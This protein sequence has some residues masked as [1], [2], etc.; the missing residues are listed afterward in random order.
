MENKPK[1]VVASANA[2]KLKEIKTIFSEFEISG[3]K[4]HG[5]DIEIQ[6]TGTTFYENAL[7]K[8]KTIS[9]I[10]GVPALAD[11]SGLEVDAL[12][13]APGIYSARYA[14]DGDDKHNNL[15]LLE[16]MKG[17]TNRTARFVCSLVYYTPD[18]QIV[19]AFGQTEGEIMHQEQGENGFGYDSLFFSKDL[20]K[21]MGIATPQEKN[22][23]SHRYR[24]LVQLREKL[25]KKL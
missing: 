9:E 25:S 16:N 10:L 20:Q 19:S 23:V 8:A 3:Y 6:E 5:V 14:G 2:G 1:L 22:S 12:N 11:D 21:G 24:A 15:L 4:E 13:G 17:I 18:G 7:I